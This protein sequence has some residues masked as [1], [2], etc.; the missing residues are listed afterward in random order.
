MMTRFGLLPLIFVLAAG[1]AGCGTVFVGFVSNPGVVPSSISGTVTI[2]HLGFSSDSNGAVVNVTQVTFVNP[3][4][5][6]T[7]AF[8]GDQ[9]TLLPVDQSLKVEFTNGT[10][11][12]TLV[13]VALL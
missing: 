10:L 13:S 8:C 2:V 12:S 3:G 11:C 9:R 5:T 7:L 1:L 6:R 4:M